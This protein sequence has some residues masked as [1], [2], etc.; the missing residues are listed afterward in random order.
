MLSR[1][2]HYKEIPN[3]LHLGLTE[4]CRTG[5]E[6]VV[7]GMGSVTKLHNE[8]RPNLDV[9]HL[10]AE[11]IIRWQGPSPTQGSEPF[12]ERALDLHFDGRRNW[13]FTTVDPRAKFHRV[14]EV[15]D[16]VNAVPNKIPFFKNK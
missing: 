10:E 2:K 8:L 5:C 4:M 9:G 3:V 14:S 13:R 16:R 6:A 15:V 7:E 11:T 1:E 12:I